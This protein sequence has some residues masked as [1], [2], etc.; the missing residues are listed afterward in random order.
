M[1]F[2]SKDYSLDLGLISFDSTKEIFFLIFNTNPVSISIKSV[3]TSIPMTS[4]VLLGCGKDNPNMT[5]LHATFKNITKCVSTI[6]IK[7]SSFAEFSTALPTLLF[8]RMSVRV[9]SLC[10]V[11][12]VMYD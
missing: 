3:K 2:K 5:L 8:F 12:P 1:P 6:I 10:Y 4:S 7:Y 11:L 9:R